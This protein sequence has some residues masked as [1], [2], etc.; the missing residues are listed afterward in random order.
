MASFQY[1]AVTADGRVMEGQLEGAGR[2]DALRQLERLGMQPVRLDESAGKSEAVKQNGSGGGLTF[3][4]TNRKVSQKALE[5][6]MRQL[7]NLLAAG[8]PLAR[9]LQLLSRESAG[10]AAAQW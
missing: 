10:A 3:G 6:F 4:L 9:A 8:V 1:K 2:G 5:N 7:S